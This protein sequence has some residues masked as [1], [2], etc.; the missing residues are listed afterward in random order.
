MLTVSDDDVLVGRRQADAHHFAP[1]SIP[2]ERNGVFAILVG[3]QN[4]R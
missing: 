3:V 4:D 1:Y 2:Q